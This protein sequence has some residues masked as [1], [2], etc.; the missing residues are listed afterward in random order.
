MRGDILIAQ[1][2]NECFFMKQGIMEQMASFL[3]EGMKIDKVVP[4]I[5]NNS[6]NM[7]RIGNIG[8]IEIDGAMY[9]KDMSGFCMSVASYQTILGY[10]NSAKEMYN[11]KE[12]AVLGFR[13]STPGGG[14]YG[15]DEVERAISNLEMPTFTHYEDIGCSA[16]IY[17]FTASDEITA[18]PMTELG[19]IGT[20]VQ[21]QKSNDDTITITSSRAKNKRL[22]LNTKEGKNKLQ[23]HLDIYENKFYEVVTKNTGFD[24]KK[25]EEEFDNGGTI[26][27]ETAAYIGFIK[28]VIAFEDLIAEKLEK[29]KNMGGN[30]SAMPTASSDKLANSNL[31]ASM[32]FNKENFDVLLESR[33]HLNENIKML[34]THLEEKT[35]VL[36]AT[37]AKLTEATAKIT[38]AEGKIES[39]KTTVV[40]RLQE[41][42][43][44]KVDLVT[45]LAMVNAGSD[46]EATKL[47]LD[48]KP[49]KALNQGEGADTKESGILAFCSQNKGSI[50]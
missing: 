14:V 50:R 22:D 1:A 35:S 37:A 42:S 23:E 47:A 38:E 20:V 34:N 39:Y 33:K 21:M 3:S 43:A 10:I 18:S 27:A 41:A 25:I 26:M 6:V 12:I 5:A 36:E 45:A 8:V 4:S 44:S 16:G 9:K 48:A 40:A 15:L 11:A 31:G 24:A 49:T 17:A 19:S 30:Q 13:V 7:R 28:E 32:E 29:Y 2:L 46:E